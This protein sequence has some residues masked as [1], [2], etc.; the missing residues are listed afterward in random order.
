MRAAGDRDL[1][2]GGRPLPSALIAATV[3]R[4]AADGTKRGFG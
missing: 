4:L 2:A 3:T 1:D